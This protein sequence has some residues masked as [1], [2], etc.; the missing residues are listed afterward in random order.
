MKNTKLQNSSLRKRKG[1][2]LIELI[3]VIA[4]LAI[5][6]AIAVPTFLNALSNAREKSDVA[7]ARVIVSAVALYI[8]E[9]PTTDP[10][11]L[12]FT[13]DGTDVLATYYDEVPTTQYDTADA[14]TYFDLATDA[15]GN[16]VITTDNNQFYPTF[17]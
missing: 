5:L 2:T 4:I 11:T 8:A 3:V 14:D 13:I 17:S 6:A 9:N 7:S 10:D 16:M 15:S 1:F 12:D